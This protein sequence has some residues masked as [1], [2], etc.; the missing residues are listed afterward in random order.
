MGHFFRRALPALLI[1]LS[2]ALTTETRAQTSDTLKRQQAFE[3][4]AKQRAAAQLKES[5]EMADRMA[6]T[7]TARGIEHLRKLQISMENEPSLSATVR[8][9]YVKQ[10][11]EKIKAME[12]RKVATKAETPAPKADAKDAS[13]ARAKA[14]VE[15]YQD[16]KRTLETIAALQKGGNT[17]QARKEADN[18]S[19][20]YPDN[21]A[22]LVLN[23]QTGMSQKLADAKVLQAQQA[24]GYRL[25]ML[26]VDKAAVPPK[27]DIEFDT[28]RKGYFKEIT[29]QRMKPTLTD[30]EMGLLKALEKPISIGA[31]NQAFESI[32]ESIS[33][34][35]GK[36]ILLEKSSLQDANIDSTTPASLPFKD[37]I[38]ARTALRLLLQP[39]RLT[40]IIKNESI[41]VVSL[42]KARENM[43]TRVYYI[44]D[45]VSGVGPFGNPLQWGTQA[46]LLQMMENANL[47]IQAMRKIDPMSWKEEGGF[48]AATFHAPSMS[49]IVR[50]SAEVH[51][52]LSSAF[53]GGGGK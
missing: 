33:E 48:G 16:V 1:P 25:A 18:L 31:N 35:I 20:K 19:R 23:E 47:I 40:F 50:Q 2:L 27:D 44:G 53:V 6:A 34:K 30:K 3:E 37:S 45:L 12:T 14:W 17:E 51:S 49:I 4:I 8:D 39:H 28:I 24:E 5:F 32:V 11:S 41:Q 13:I 36:P 10:I 42:E 7:S 26:S 43:I 52:Q 15:E 38:Q 29:K 21:P 9:Q 46:S 22:V